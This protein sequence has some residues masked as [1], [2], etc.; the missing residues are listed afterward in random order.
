MV[1]K[2]TGW[3][4][5]RDASSARSKSDQVLACLHLRP[6]DVVGDIG[7]GGGFFTFAFAGEVGEGGKVYAIDVKAD[8]LGQIKDQATE[9]GIR[10]VEAVLVEGDQLGLPERSVDLFFAR[11]VF[12]HL[13]EPVPYFQNLKRFMKPAGRV[14]IIDHVEPKGITFI[15]VFGHYTSTEVILSDMEEAGFTLSESFSF[16]RT[17]S[18]NVFTPR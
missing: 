2:L 1:S 18:F 16:L 17:Q 3:L 9:R 5:N 7:S 14:A 12:H 13:P 11:D 6:G 10:N 15:R 4:Y 8:F